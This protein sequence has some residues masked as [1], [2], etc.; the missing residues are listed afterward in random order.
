MERGC[1]EKEDER[2]SKY[3]YADIYGI[4][5]LGEVRDNTDCPILVVGWT[6]DVE[7]TIKERVIHSS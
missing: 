4:K 5:Y 2:N 6:I 7:N 3:G 1:E